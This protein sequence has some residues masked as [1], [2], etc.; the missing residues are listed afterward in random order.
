L[1]LLHPLCR[2]SRQTDEHLGTVAVTSLLLYAFCLQTYLLLYVTFLWIAW[3]GYQGILAY[4]PVARGDW[5]KIDPNVH[6][7]PT[8]GNQKLSGVGI[9][10]GWQ[11]CSS[12]TATPAIQRQTTWK[13]DSKHLQ[14]RH[15]TMLIEPVAFPDC[16]H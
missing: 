10:S 6:V 1:Q 3:P 9:S 16:S 11:N 14:R 2:I 7:T 15:G 5:R 8:S 12:A 13:S 4:N